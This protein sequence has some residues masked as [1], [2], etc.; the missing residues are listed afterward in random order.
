[1]RIFNLKP[2]REVGVLKTAVRE[3]ILDGEIP[4]EHDAAYQLLLERAAAMGLQP[5]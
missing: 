3:A 4:N 2:S 1:M 5:V